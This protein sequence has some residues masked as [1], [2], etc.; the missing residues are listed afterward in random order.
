VPSDPTAFAARND[1]SSLVWLFADE[2]STS[3][4]LRQIASA[5]G[6]DIDHYGAV[7]FG[8]LGPRLS[9]DLESALFFRLRR[10]YDEVL[11]ERLLA[12]RTS[13]PIIQPERSPEPSDDEGS[14]PPVTEASSWDA[15]EGDVDAE[16][17]R[18][19]ATARYS[20]RLAAQE[21]ELTRHLQRSTRSVA[22][23]ADWYAMLRADGRH[24]ADRTVTELESLRNRLDHLID[25]RINGHRG[26]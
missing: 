10:R 1:L 26:R 12:D 3:E 9:P 11:D 5:V 4:A 6:I 24:G 15:F 8:E 20:L 25:Q 21:G 19:L 7:A 14:V 13:L 17:Q 2:P 18:L 16:M 23:A 22:E